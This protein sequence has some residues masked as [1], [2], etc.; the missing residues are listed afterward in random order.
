[1]LG[2]ARYALRTDTLQVP[3]HRNNW[4]S[5]F[6]ALHGRPLLAR[7]QS[8]EAYANQEESLCVIGDRPRLF[9]QW[10]SSYRSSTLAR[11]RSPLE[12]FFDFGLEAFVAQGVI[13]IGCLAYLTNALRVDVCRELVAIGV[14]TA[15]QV[16]LVRGGHRIG[17][18]VAVSAIARPGVVTWMPHEEI[19]A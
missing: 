6:H 15:P 18:P 7:K 3:G 5:L 16:L 19:E 2:I 17:K 12:R 8:V 11:G 9:D 13:A 4:E 1:M 10:P 14:A